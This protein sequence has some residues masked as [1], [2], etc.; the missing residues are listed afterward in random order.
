MTAD[1][2][3]NLILDSFHQSRY[4]DEVSTDNNLVSD[5]YDED[6]CYDE[7]YRKRTLKVPL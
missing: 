2:M 4:S 1:A 3:L 7:L 5:P 6:F